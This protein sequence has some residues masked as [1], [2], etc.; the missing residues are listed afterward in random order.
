MDLTQVPLPQSSMQNGTMTLIP[1]IGA[2]LMQTST[3]RSLQRILTVYRALDQLHT[4]LH[5]YLEEIAK[6]KISYL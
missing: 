3:V 4:L 1:Q 5:E 6:I 2:F